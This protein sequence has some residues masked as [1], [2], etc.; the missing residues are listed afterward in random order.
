MVSGEGFGTVSLHRWILLLAFSGTIS[1]F[2]PLIITEHGMRSDLLSEVEDGVSL[3]VKVW[4]EKEENLTINTKM[5][6]I[7]LACLL[8]VMS[9]VQSMAQAPDLS[10]RCIEEMKKLSYLVGDWE[11]TAIYR[12]QQGQELHLLQKEHIE[13]RLRGLIITIDNIGL[14]QNKKEIVFQTFAILH[15]DPFAKEFRFKT[16]LK[17]GY[18]V[19]AYFKVIE[20]NKFEWGFDFPDR[21]KY[22][23]TI[24]LD[25]LEKTWNETGEFSADGKKWFTSIELN[26]IKQDSKYRQSD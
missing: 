13:L 1:L 4:E 10:E 2:M 3:E 19:D 25:P 8:L 18:S 24:M 21:G 5:K 9:G 6:N 15:F 26:L 11:G 14:D 7:H 16:F 20:A 12:A 17:E 22:K 23:Y